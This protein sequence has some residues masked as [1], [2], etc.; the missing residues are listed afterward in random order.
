MVSRGTFTILTAPVGFFAHGG[1]PESD[2]EEFLNA[3]FE[4]ETYSESEFDAY[5]GAAE[6]FF[7]V[8][9]SNEVDAYDGA[10]ESDYSRVDF[11][12][13]GGMP[14]FVDIQGGPIDHNNMVGVGDIIPGLFDAQPVDPNHVFDPAYNEQIGSSE[15]FDAIFNGGDDFYDYVTTPTN[16]SISAISDVGDI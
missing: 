4:S 2:D 16:T 3:A 13:S 12:K 5:D 7:D 10:A 1:H 15:A 14:L 6:S 11:A 8:F 9:Q